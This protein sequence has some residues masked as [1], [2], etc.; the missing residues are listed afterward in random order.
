MQVVE[1]MSIDLD[2]KAMDELLAVKTPESFARAKRIYMEGGHRRS[3]AMINLTEPLGFEVKKD[4]H[5]FFG[6][7]A[8]GRVVTANAYD[9]YAVNSTKIGLRYSAIDNQEAYQTC[10]VGALT[11]DQRNLHGCLAPEGFVKMMSNDPKLVYQYKYDP[12]VS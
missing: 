12:L 5:L 10:T 4:A 3:Y 1:H 11:A 2:K 7:T 6:K 9:N 8:E